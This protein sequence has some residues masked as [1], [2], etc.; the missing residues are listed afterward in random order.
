MLRESTMALTESVGLLISSV[1]LPWQHEDRGRK[2]AEPLTLVTAFIPLRAIAR[3]LV[4]VRGLDRPMR[5]PA[6]LRH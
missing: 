4:V 2:A 1:P 6:T 3:P 5:P